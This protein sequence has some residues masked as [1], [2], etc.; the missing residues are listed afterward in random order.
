MYNSYTPWIFY[1]SNVPIDCP[2]MCGICKA[3]RSPGN[4]FIPAP[5]T[6]LIAGDGIVHVLICNPVQYSGTVTA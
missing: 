3:D 1:F 4:K 6:Q 2:I 5:A